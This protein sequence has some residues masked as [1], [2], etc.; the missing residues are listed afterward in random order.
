MPR[1]QA[2]AAS[3]VPQEKS[4]EIAIGSALSYLQTASLSQKKGKFWSDAE[5]EIVADEIIALMTDEELLAQTFMFG[6]TGSKPSAL[7]LDWVAER[8][9]G[10]V[11]LFGW[12]TASTEQV[13]ASVTQLQALAAKNRFGIPLFVATDQEGGLIRHVKGKTSITPGNLAL[14]ASGY[15][16]DAYK[17]GYYISRELHALGINMNFAPSV[18]VY[19]TSE[20]SIIGTRSFG[21]N[22]EACG[23]LGAAF[24][25]GSRSAGVI[26]TAKHFPGHGGTGA[27]SHIVL[28][29]IDI[30]K[31]TLDARELVPFKRLIE[32][33]VEAIMSGHLSFPQLEKDGTP[34]SLSKL[35]LTDILRGEL[36]FSGLII[37]DD[38]M[39][40]GAT[41]YA[42][43][44][45]KAVT[46][47]LNAG[48]DIIMASTTAP[49]DANLWTQNLALMRSSREFRAKIQAAAKR[50]L[51]CKL[52]Y[53]KSPQAAPLYPATESIVDFAA[54]DGARNETI[55][56]D[57]EGQAFFAEAARRSITLEYPLAFDKSV[58]PP[59]VPIPAT[60][61]I[62]LVPN[63]YTDF[64]KA[65]KNY[66]P[67]ALTDLRIG[68]KNNAGA[69]VIICVSDS[70][71][72]KT[73]E[74][75]KNSG[76]RV[77]VVSVS[78]PAYA[79]GLSWTDAIVYTYSASPFS[80]DAAFAVI[81]GKIPATGKMPVA[82]A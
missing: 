58:N 2:S 46:L 67:H 37:T 4:S 16:I 79:A 15:P 24:A 9:L 73:A 13:A 69:T 51:M 52:R 55:L 18:D 53:F 56:P 6:W 29:R 47:S 80:L 44:L 35:F 21:S 43:S 48:N 50:S 3:T 23:I 40:N 8:S 75:Y 81:A 60:E 82:P 38:M 76:Y 59:I 33:N 61:K 72:A 64:E 32:E 68:A 36:G 42:G 39:M 74:R 62:L 41:F 71:D 11:K 10:G 5:D 66:F 28:P 25:A 34:A 20:S 26:A 57:A 27:D 63:G 49:L 78:A 31:K 1:E 19:S 54:P 14:G 45:A 30:S 12:N 17:S 7:L 65:A 70:A 77:L 22:P